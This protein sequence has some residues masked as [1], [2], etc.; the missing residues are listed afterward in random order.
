MPD[1][2]KPR[3]NPITDTP[4]TNAACQRDYQSGSDVR[5]VAANQ[6]SLQNARKPRR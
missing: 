5:Q 2:R 1:D 6:Q 4:A 3:P